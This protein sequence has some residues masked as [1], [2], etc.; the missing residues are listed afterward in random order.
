MLFWSE[1]VMG[2]NYLTTRLGLAGNIEGRAKFETD[3]LTGF[4]RDL[5]A[6]R[7]GGRRAIDTMCQPIELNRASHGT[8]K[9]AVDVT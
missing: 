7:K 9:H 5:K 8:W 6:K 4:E 3:T 1:L 2:P